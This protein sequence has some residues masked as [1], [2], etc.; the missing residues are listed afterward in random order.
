MTLIELFLGKYKFIL[1]KK[2]TNYGPKC[3]MFDNVLVTLVIFVI[4]TVYNKK[5]GMKEE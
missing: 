3:V 4:K 2:L 5:V 1:H